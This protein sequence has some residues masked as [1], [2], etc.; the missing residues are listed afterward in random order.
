MCHCRWLTVDS[1]N[2]TAT[3][4]SVDALKLF[5]NESFSF[6]WFWMIF[7]QSFTTWKLLKILCW[8]ILFSTTAIMENLLEVI[9]VPSPTFSFSVSLHFH[10][11]RLSQNRSMNE[12]KSF[13]PLRLV[14]LPLEDF[15]YENQKQKFIKWK[16]ESR[17][18]GVRRRQRHTR[19][20]NRWICQRVARR[21]RKAHYTRIVSSAASK[22]MSQECA[23]EHILKANLLN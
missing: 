21:S 22:E 14:R 3:E 12:S 23:R 9:S 13:F 17:N 16:R 10:H 11:F 8:F 1:E 18:N 4:S 19:K 5:R 7:A 15:E 20:S 6:Y 2:R